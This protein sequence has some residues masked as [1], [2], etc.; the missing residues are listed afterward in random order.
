M[1]GLGLQFF[2]RLLPL[3]RF[4]ARFPSTY[5]ARAPALLR[6]FRISFLL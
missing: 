3:F 5:S 1:S 6:E 2:S 4:Y